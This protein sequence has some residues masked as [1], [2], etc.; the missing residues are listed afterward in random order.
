VTRII[1]YVPVRVV[2]NLTEGLHTLTNNIRPNRVV[3]KVTHVRQES[4]CQSQDS[5]TTILYLQTVIHKALEVR[6]PF[7][8][9]E[10][11]GLVG[12]HLEL[13]KLFGLTTCGWNKPRQLLN[14]FLSPANGKA[15]NGRVC[16]T[17]CGAL[18]HATD[19]AGA[20]AAAGGLVD[21]RDCG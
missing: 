10:R 4:L 8:H 19:C 18:I 7:R 6:K 2:G 1:L 21:G 14:T 15:L 9:W 16:I 11:L 12:I 20:G 5:L 17:L 3:V 13:W